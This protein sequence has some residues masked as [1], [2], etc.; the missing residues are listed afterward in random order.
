MSTALLSFHHYSAIRTTLREMVSSNQHTDHSYIRPLVNYQRQRGKTFGQMMDF[1][2][3]MVQSMY[4]VNCMAYE[5]DNTDP[6]ELEPEVVFEPAPVLSPVELFKAMQAWRYN[7]VYT[8]ES[9]DIILS[10]PEQD[11]RSMYLAL[12]VLH[13]IAENILKHLYEY[14]RAKWML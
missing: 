8:L 4:K 13:T 6:G 3:L 11:G 14:E 9:D 1:I 7:S 5:Y 2:D 12:E 10:V